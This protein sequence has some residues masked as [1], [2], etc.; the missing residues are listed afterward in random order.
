MGENYPFM[1]STTALMCITAS[2]QATIYSIIAERN[3]SVW[4]LGWNIRLFSA[5][6]T[7]K[8][9]SIEFT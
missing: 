6:Y 4:K 8:T 5:V 2:I 7:V 9:V 1:Y 3:W